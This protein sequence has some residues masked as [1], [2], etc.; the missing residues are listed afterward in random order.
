[1]HPRTRWLEAR[2]R[3]VTTPSI[4]PPCVRESRLYGRIGIRFDPGPARRV[5]GV[6]REDGMD[7]RIDVGHAKPAVGSGLRYRRFTQ[8]SILRGFFRDM[9]GSLSDRSAG[10]IAYDAFHDGAFRCR[11]LGIGGRLD[12][13]ER[14]L[15]GVGELRGIDRMNR[16][17][18]FG[19]RGLGLREGRGRRLDWVKRH[20]RS[21]RDVPCDERRDDY[22]G[23][24]DKRFV[25]KNRS[26]DSRCGCNL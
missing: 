10:L 23:D 6:I 4:A 26:R 20:V 3:N 16:R 1:M 17:D 11:S 9:D 22:C 19:W 21:A 25:H 2:R 8:H 24:T 15:Q 7:L 5:I 14:G 13:T 12:G 18:G